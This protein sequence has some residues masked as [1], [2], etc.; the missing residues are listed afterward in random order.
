VI[1]LRRTPV[2]SR[3]TEQRISRYTSQLTAEQRGVLAAA[4]DADAPVT[5]GYLDS[6]GRHT[7]RVIDQLELDGDALVAWCH[8]RNDERRFLLDRIDA[9]SPA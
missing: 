7:R 9:V 2:A 4:I 6:G 8:L 1:P 3:S 5:I